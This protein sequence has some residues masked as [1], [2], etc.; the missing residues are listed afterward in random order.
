MCDKNVLN[1]FNIKRWQ[2]IRWQTNILNDG[3][4]SDD[5]QTRLKMTVNVFQEPYRQIQ[6]D[7]GERTLSFQ[8]RCGNMLISHVVL[9]S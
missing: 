5:K 3:S 9:A 6:L 1:Y 7:V 2:S 8:I 4:L